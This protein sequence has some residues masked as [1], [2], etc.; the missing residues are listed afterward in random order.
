MPL[1][2]WSVATDAEIDAHLECVGRM[3]VH[4]LHIKLATLL[5]VASETCFGG[6]REARASTLRWLSSPRPVHQLHALVALLNRGLIICTNSSGEDC[7]AE[8]LEWSPDELHSLVAP[9]P[10][11]TKSDWPHLQSFEA[12]LA[13]LT[14]EEEVGGHSESELSPPL[15]ASVPTI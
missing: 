14:E 3:H 10:Q 4:A 9:V 2:P 7:E 13:A 6:D 11:T 12:E 15:G 8:F 5:E 1:L